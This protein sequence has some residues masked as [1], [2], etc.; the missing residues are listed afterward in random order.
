MQAHQL[1]TLRRNLLEKK[2]AVEEARARECAQRGNKRGAGG[3]LACTAGSV[4]A[5]AH[6]ASAQPGFDWRTLTIWRPCL[7]AGALTALRQK[8]LLASNLEQVGW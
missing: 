6:T 2:I 4:A 3:G 8:K 7:C 5:T 1:L